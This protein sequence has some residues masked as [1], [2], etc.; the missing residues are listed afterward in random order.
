MAIES[1]MAPTVIAALIAAAVGIFTTTISLIL[2]LISNKSKSNDSVRL[3]RYTKLYEIL[4]ELAHTNMAIDNKS[5]FAIVDARRENL[6]R[7]YGMAKPLVS[8]EYWADIDVKINLNKELL[9]E[10]IETGLFN[11]FYEDYNKSVGI[12]E[13]DFNS[14]IEKQMKA[15]LKSK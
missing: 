8:E 3:F 9:I 14:A 4:H 5:A 11:E 7:S 10:I 2:A 1:I 6:L 15:L 13:L 12:M